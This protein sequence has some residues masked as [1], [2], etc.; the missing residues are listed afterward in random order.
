MVVLVD[1]VEWV[2]FSVGVM[3]VFECEVFMMW[4]WG[5]CV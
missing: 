2:E 4:L 5:M 1:G 3:I